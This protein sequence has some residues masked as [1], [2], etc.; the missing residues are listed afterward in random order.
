MG[1]HRT[2]GD[3]FGSA[4]C[5][6]QHT[7]CRN[8]QNPIPVFFYEFGALNI[9][10]GAVAHI[11][12]YAVDFDSEARSRTVEIDYIWADRVL[13]AKFKAIR[14]KPQRLP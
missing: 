6:R 8:P 12:H 7:L 5:I 3:C 14:T 9:L 2:R 11:M 1:A 10:L 13:A 4:D